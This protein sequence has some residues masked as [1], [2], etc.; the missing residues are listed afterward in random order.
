[1]LQEI[2]SGIRESSRNLNTV[3]KIGV[4]EIGEYLS[5]VI[6]PDFNRLRL[7]P[8]FLLEAGISAE[9][10][11]QDTPTRLVTGEGGTHLAASYIVGEC[12]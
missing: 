4:L 5:S 11:E 7:N 9:A 2:L 8:L 1:M 10:S 6:V 12:I 3:V